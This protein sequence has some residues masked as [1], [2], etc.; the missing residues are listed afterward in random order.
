MT[1]NT[2]TFCQSDKEYIRSF[3]FLRW[4]IVLLAS[5]LTFFS[6]IEKPMFLWVVLFAAAFAMS[7]VVFMLLPPA[8]FRNVAHQKAIIIADVLFCCMTFYLLK[9]PGTYLYFPFM[10]IYIMAAIRRDMKAVA[11]SLIS[12]SLF[13][14]VFSLLRVY[15]HY[16]EASGL[17]GADFFLEDLEHVLTLSLFFVAAVFYLFLSDRLRQD[18]VLSG[19]LHAE[20]RRAEITGEISRSLLSSLNSQEVLYLIVTR[21]CE[22]FEAEEC[23]IVR[24]DAGRSTAKLLVKS[25]Q[26]EARDCDI[27]LSAYPEIQHAN[28]ARDLLFVPDVQRNGESHAVIVMPMLAH[29]SVLGIIH[30]QF[31]G[32]R[33]PLSEE[34]IRFCRIMSA[35]AANALRNAQVFE[36]MEHRARTDYLT[37]L[38]NHRFFQTTLDNEIARAR[39]HGHSLSLLIVDLDYLKEV[40]DRFGHLTGDSVIREVAETIRKGCRDFD[41]AARYGGEEFTIILPETSLEDAVRVAERIREQIAN[42]R[43]PGAGHVTAS[44]GVSSYPQNANNKEELIHAA[45]RALYTAKNNG[46]NKVWH[47]TTELIA[48]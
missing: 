1:R 43:F 30:V 3:L 2:T 41:F 44:I 37:G 19:M 42:T 7:N 38:H 39:R 45:D 31:S 27:D 14:G 46:R 21:L 28:E 16:S 40:N 9:V 34:E 35:T 25:A 29:D 4:L 20:K 6:Y 10:L 22:V 5:Y 47:F 8:C 26:P 11:F 12:V 23:S 36:E 15:G 48:R 24:L 13:H 33:D 17:V 18:A 32:A